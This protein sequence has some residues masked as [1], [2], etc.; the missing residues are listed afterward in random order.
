MTTSVSQLST[1]QVRMLGTLNCRGLMIAS[2]LPVE[3]FDSYVE[4][5]QP[6]LS[7]HPHEVRRELRAWLFGDPPGLHKAVSVHD[8]DFETIAALD[9]RAKLILAEQMFDYMVGLETRI[10]CTVR[11]M[12]ESGMLSADRRG[13]MQT[14]RMHSHAIKIVHRYIR[15]FEKNLSGTDLSVM[16]NYRSSYAQV[17]IEHDKMLALIDRFASIGEISDAYIAELVKVQRRAFRILEDKGYVTFVARHEL[18]AGVCYGLMNNA[19][20]SSW[21]GRTLEIV[22]PLEGMKQWREGERWGMLGALEWPPPQDDPQL[23]AFERILGWKFHV[24]PP[25]EDS[26]MIGIDFGD[27]YYEE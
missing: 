23:K 15:A 24:S 1:L 4:R 27:A 18:S 3:A 20:H 2:M 22:M 14:Y 25:T 16:R 17:G 21:A 5:K 7:G 26:V 10:A 12:L 9:P 11:T 6:V 8:L 19:K 13:K